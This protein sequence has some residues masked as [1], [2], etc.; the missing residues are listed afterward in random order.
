MLR[1]EDII[2]VRKAEARNG[3][4]I[5]FPDNKIIWVVKRRCL[6]GILLLIKYEYCSEADLVGANNR[7]TTIKRLLNGKNQPFV[8]SRSLW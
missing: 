8:D 2:I 1:V 7:L 6:A 5:V 3:Y 4:E